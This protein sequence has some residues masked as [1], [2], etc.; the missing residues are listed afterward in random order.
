MTQFAEALKKW[1]K[2][3]RFSQLDLAAEADVSTRHLSFLE[4]GRAQPSREMIGKLGDALSLPLAARNQL[5]AQAG[6]AAPG[7][8]RSPSP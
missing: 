4:T 8:P 3:R 1:R 6:F 5:M 2:T 7:V